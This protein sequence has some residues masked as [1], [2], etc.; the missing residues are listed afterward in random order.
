VEYAPAAP[1]SSYMPLPTP[2]PAVTSWSP[3]DG[4]RPRPP[5]DAAAIGRSSLHGRAAKLTP[6]YSFPA[7]GRVVTPPPLTA[8][9]G[10]PSRAAFG[11]I[12]TADPPH[13][14]A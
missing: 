14:E 10:S 9:P 12:L 3:R 13:A 7:T 11:P 1:Q 5:E 4:C 8:L 2:P 6:A